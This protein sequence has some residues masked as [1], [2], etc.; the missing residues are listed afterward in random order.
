MSS[1]GTNFAPISSLELELPNK[2]SDGVDCSP[3]EELDSLDSFTFK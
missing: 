1:I 2:F 3:G